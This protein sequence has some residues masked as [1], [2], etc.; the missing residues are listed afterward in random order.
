MNNE[1]IKR[2]ASSIFLIPLTFF[3]IIKGSYFFYFLLG[4]I[5]L[6]ASLEWHSMSKNKSYYFFW[7][8]IFNNFNTLR[9]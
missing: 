1:I 8:Y 9:L 3:C 6:I 7:L 5:Y 4:L 2:I